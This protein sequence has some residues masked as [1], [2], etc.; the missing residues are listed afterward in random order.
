MYLHASTGD[1]DDDDDDDDDDDWRMW[2]YGLHF[3]GG[4]D[5]VEKDGMPAISSQDIGLERQTWEK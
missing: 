2:L 4:D 3:H 1:G 5:M